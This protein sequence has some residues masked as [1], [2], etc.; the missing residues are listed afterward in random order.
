MTRRVGRAARAAA[1]HRRNLGGVVTVVVHHR[2]A[3]DD[4]DMLEA[5]L[6]ATKVGEG[7]GNPRERDIE[8]ETNR[9]GG[10]RVQHRV[11]AGH[12]QGEDAEHGGRS[13]AVR[14]TA[15]DDAARAE[16][17]EQHL[18]GA[19]ARRPARRYRR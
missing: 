14:M 4:A 8:L 15:L 9:H 11:P 6:G 17:F 12:L 2:D 16:T 13:I 7:L 10:Q 18:T 5:A 19:V 1:T 3:I